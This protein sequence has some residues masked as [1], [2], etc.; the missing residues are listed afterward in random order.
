[1]PSPVPPA[2]P[3]TYLIV[4]SQGVG[5]LTVAP[6]QAAGPL[7]QVV[8]TGG[9]AGYAPGVT[10]NVA[11]TGGTGTGAEASVVVTG[12]VITGVT[13]TN[14]GTGYLVSDV[15]LIPGGSTT[16]TVIVTYLPA[17]IDAITGDPLSTLELSGV[18]ALNWGSNIWESL[19]R[20]TESFAAPTAPGANLVLG[21]TKVT[22]VYGQL[23]FDTATQTLNVY[24]TSNWIPLATGGVSAIIGT[25]PIVVVSGGGTPV[26]NLQTAVTYAVIAD[27][28]ITN[29]GPTTL[30]G[31]LGLFP[32]TSVTGAPTV[33][34]ATNINN[35]AAHQAILDATTAYNAGQALAGATVLS[36]STYDF[37]GGTILPGL[38]S[39]GSGATI[40]TGV[41]LDAGGNPDATFIFQ[42]GSTLTVPTSSVVTLAGGAQAKNVYWL[43]GSSAT[44]AGT[45]TFNGTLIAQVSISMGTG[46]TVTGHL[47]ALTGAVTLLSNTVTATPAGSGAGGIVDISLANSPVVPGSYTDANITVDQFGRIT[48]A[49]NGIPSG[50]GTVTSVAATT[51]SAGLTISGSPITTAGTL[52]INLTG[53]LNGLSGLSTLGFVQRTGVN[54]FTAAALTLSN[55]TTALGYTPYNGVTNP[56]GFLTATTLPA[57][58]GD[59][60]KPA[61]S[62]VTT[63]ANNV[64]TNAKL[65]QAPARTLKG[66][67]TAVTANVADLTIAQV[68]A[69]LPLFT[70][71]A[72]G[73]VGAS[74]GGT[75]NFLRADGTWA[76]T[77]GAPT[78]LAT[79]IVIFDS[80]V[81]S[82][83]KVSG[84]V[85]STHGPL[86][87]GWTNYNL[88]S[89]LGVVAKAVI[90]EGHWAANAPGDGSVMQ[91]I[92]AG[93]IL[94]RADMAKG[95]TVVSAGQ[96]GPWV[97]TFAVAKSISADYQYWVSYQS[98]NQGTYPVRQAAQIESVTV[99]G[100]GG[101]VT[102][103]YTL[104]AGSIDYLVPSPFAG[105]GGLGGAAIRIVG[106][107]T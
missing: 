45:A 66:N 78:M 17:S 54:T 28:T 52:T 102:T 57:F 27:T 31:D 5:V 6:Q 101:P 65:A 79:P 71:V 75:T 88:A 98:I 38:Y 7:M 82:T 56:L 1:M 13:I 25:S 37:A 95:R 41:T 43:V 10:N 60:T 97:D 39:I 18:N 3:P 106:Y 51:T 83:G 94:E 4:N 91:N 103:N 64:V 73:I 15:L 36:A 33:T 86:N 46:A 100:K 44:F 81:F 77:G 8:V 16:A 19:Y 80:G 49:S 53:N 68:M 70:A 105:S 23:W 29:S 48:A 58:T 47:F 85:Y 42:I 61:N 32:G 89:V 30:N 34:G 22:P 84:G 14:N 104:P 63:I 92:Q 35:P 87:N 99:S 107:Y 55:I 69:M 96:T 62:T 12:N 9:G 59:V 90:L 11:L 40:T 20:L 67:N 74:G 93:Y 72:S 2:N 24:T 76:P 50:G 26:I 21:G